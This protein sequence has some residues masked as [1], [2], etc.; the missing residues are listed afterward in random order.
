MSQIL[1]ITL[2][3]EQGKDNFEKKKTSFKTF[4]N[5]IPC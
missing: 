2:V 1:H 4:E 5:V 3:F